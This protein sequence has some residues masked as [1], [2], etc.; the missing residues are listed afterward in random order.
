MLVYQG[1]LS[2]SLWLDRPVDTIPVLAMERAVRNT[3]AAK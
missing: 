2:L 1:A 3:I